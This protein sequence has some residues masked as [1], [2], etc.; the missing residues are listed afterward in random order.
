MNTMKKTV[1]A[2]LVTASIGVV[3]LPATAA[4]APII[5]PVPFL[6]ITTTE[7]DDVQIDTDGV[8]LAASG[9]AFG[10]A[11]TPA[12]VNWEQ[13]SFGAT[14]KLTGSIYLKNVSQTCAKVQLISYDA[15]G[16]EIGLVADRP[17]SSQICA[18]N[19]DF[20][21]GPIID[22]STFTPYLQGQPLASEV[23]VR[24]LTAANVLPAI[25]VWLPLGNRLK[26]YGPTLGTSEVLISASKLDFGIGVFAGGTYPDPATVTWS[27]DGANL[28]KASTVG[29]LA[30]KNAAFLCSRLRY[31]YLNQSIF[32]IG[33]TVLGTQYGRTHCVTTDQLQEFAI[34]ANPGT[35]AN[36]FSYAAL[37]KVEIAIEQSSV[38]QLTLNQNPIE[39][40]GDWIV[41]GTPVT[42]NLPSAP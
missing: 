6:G 19:N 31:T 18:G 14:S 27:V 26:E 41:V 24:L 42:V 7:I 12:K 40:N 5:L 21:E 4:L 15:S 3:A 30:M 29:S 34:N 16:A 37:D 9:L 39:S 20:I 13:G 17:E 32:F 36:A 25:Q 23:R 2:S 38:N 28:I 22:Q 33:D 1:L 8:D 11:L 35:A 10:A